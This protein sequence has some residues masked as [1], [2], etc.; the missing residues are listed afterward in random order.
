[1]MRIAAAFISLFLIVGSPVGL[2]GLLLLRADARKAERA[3]LH[4]EE[5][6]R[7]LHARTG[8]WKPV[9]TPFRWP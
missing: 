3:R 1:M 2:V 8:L 4:R 7:E 6:R 5:R 9:D